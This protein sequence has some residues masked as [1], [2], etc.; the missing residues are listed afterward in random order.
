MSQQQISVFIFHR[1]LRLNYNTSLIK[2]IK[3]GYRILPVF[4]F[5]PEQIDPEVNEYFSHPAVQFM[6]E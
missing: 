4:I 1:D 3:D 5:P 6:C 2:A